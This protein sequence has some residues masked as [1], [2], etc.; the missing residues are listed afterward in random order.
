[1]AVT[2]TTTTASDLQ[3]TAR[4]LY[5]N[6]LPV[7]EYIRKLAADLGMSESGVKKIW[8]AQRGKESL[9]QSVRNRL[10]KRLQASH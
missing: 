7:A 1:M 10:V 3:S 2:T 4:V 9:S 8:Y 5:G 6:D